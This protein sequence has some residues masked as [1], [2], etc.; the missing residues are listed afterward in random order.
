MV[1]SGV[2]GM[3]D[4]VLATVIYI[5]IA[6]VVCVVPVVFFV[7][8]LSRWKIFLKVGMVLL[9]VVGFVT[10]VRWKWRPF[11]VPPVPITP[12]EVQHHE[13][14]T[15]RVIMIG[16]SW[17]YFHETLRRDSTFE[18]ELKRVL[19]SQKVKV[20]AKGLA[21]STSGEIYQRMSAERTM[22]MDYDLTYCSQPVIEAGADY[23]VISAGINDARQRRGKVYYVGS[24]LRLLRLL[25]SYGIRPVVTEVPQVEVDEAFIGNTLYYR[26]KARI[27]LSILKTELY[28][29]DDYRRVLKDSLMSTHLMDSV[30]YI[31]AAS[32]NPEGWKDKRNIYTDDNFHLNLPG[33]ALLDS[34]YAAAIVNDYR[35]RK[36]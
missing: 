1:L 4:T 36:K 24:Y 2:S 21:G 20:T 30:I 9:I 23:C 18:D 16:D 10:F 34:V 15:L 26:M 6:I 28:G 32:W 35:K 22:E 31:S 13:D 8:G 5:L 17:V 19:K 12:Y 7:S 27:C 3:E 29:V 33:Y 14:D 11:Y 25:L